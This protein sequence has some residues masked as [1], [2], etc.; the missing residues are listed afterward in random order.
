MYVCMYWREDRV[1]VNY[2]V[3]HWVEKMTTATKGILMQEMID[4][5]Y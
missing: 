4:A 2:Y 5:N 3:T 1:N